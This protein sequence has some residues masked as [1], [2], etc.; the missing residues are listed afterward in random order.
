MS[1]T[2]KQT[3][4]FLLL[5]IAMVFLFLVN[6]SLGSVAIPLKE[7]ANG[8][9]AKPMIKESWEIILWNF[10]IPKA[11]TAVLVGIGLSISG[12]LMQTLFRN[13]LAGPYVLGLSSG[14]SLGVAFIILGTGFLPISIAT[15]FLSNYGLVIASSLGSFFVLLA[16]LLVSQQLKD[17]MAILIV[18]LM[19]GSFTSAIVSV[20]SYFTSAEKLQKFTFWSMGSISNL[21]WNEIS[22]L[23]LFVGIGIGISFMVIKPLNAL[24]LGEKYAQSIGINYKKTRLIIIIAT[25]ILA[26]SITAFAGP[27]AFIGLAVPHIAKL[28]FQTSNHFVLFW[29]TL[30]LGAIVMLCCDTIAQVPGNDIT[31][32]INAITSVMGAPVV[33]W[34][35]VRKKRY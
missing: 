11:I 19:F 17:T 31:L 28:L 5:L 20:L 16:V 21:S 30:L 27:I 3:F 7:I 23:T 13:P 32:P 4:L 10:R 6:V 1:F 22:L 18:G 8:L 24:L 12:L 2:K 35:L 15:F 14:A 25:S 33:I 34:L 26:G 9:F 29:S